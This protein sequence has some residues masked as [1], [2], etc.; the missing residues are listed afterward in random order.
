MAAR[1]CRKCELTDAG[2]DS[3]ILAQSLVSLPMKFAPLLLSLVLF[4]PLHADEIVVPGGKIDLQFASPPPDALRPLVDRWIAM[5]AQ[6]VAA[7]YGK[8][9]VERVSLRISPRNGRG[10]SR[11]TTYGSP[12]A[13]I[14][15]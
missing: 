14:V 11:G 4:V 9:P 15:I 10:V 13:R 3:V 5:A 12:T 2:C 7:Y 1:D 8:F 6:S